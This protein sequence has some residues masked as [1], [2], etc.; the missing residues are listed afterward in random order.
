MEIGVI[1]VNYGEIVKKNKL[2]LLIKMMGFFICVMKIFLNILLLLKFVLYYMGL[3]LMF[4]KLKERK[5]LIMGV[6]LMLKLKKKVY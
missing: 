1:K 6:F 3:L 4:I 2:I 5:M